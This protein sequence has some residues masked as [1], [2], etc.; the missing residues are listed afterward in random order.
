MIPGPVFASAPQRV[1]WEVTRAC[2]LACR[3]CRV[4]AAPDPDRKELSTAEGLALIERLARFGPPGPHLVLTGGD[5]LKRQDLFLLIERARQGLEVRLLYDAVGSMGLDGRR[6]KALVAAGGRAEGFMPMNPLRR[7]WSLDLRNHRKL[8]IVDGA[9]AF[10]G[11]MNV[12][13]EYSGRS[14]RRGSTHYHDTHLCLRGPVVADLARIF[15]E[16][17]CFAADESLALPPRPGPV[18]GGG[19]VVAVVPSGPDQEHNAN[20]MVYF[21]AIAMARER[22]HLATPYFIPDE[23]TLRALLSAALRGVDVRLLLPG[24]CDLAVVRAAARTYYPI[25][26]DAGV[27]VF[28]YQPSMLHGKTLTVDGLW[29]IVGSANV[30]IRS[31]RRN[32]ELGAL[33]ADAPFAAAMEQRFVGD[34]AE[35]REVTAEVL[36]QAGTWDKLRDRTARLLS[37]LL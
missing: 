3:H 19:A 32:F 34:L 8:I 37:P 17:W 22:V 20:G 36:D 5:A 26:L 21:T 30:D 12:G 35:S 7:R 33:V 10:T 28:E 15:A 23:P 27:R 2:D 9:L 11:G 13:D 24:P 25:L 29:S 16:D 4:E 6:L 18:P 1:Y 14:R 31:F